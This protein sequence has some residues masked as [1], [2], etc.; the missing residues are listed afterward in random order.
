V[1]RFRFI[2]A[3]KAHHAV[4]LLCRVLEVST[5]G[6]YAWTQRPPS[7]RAEADGAL[8]ARIRAV[9]RASRGTYGAP[10][11]HAELR[12][13]GRPVARKRIARLM[14]TDGLRGCRPRRFVRT[15]LAEPAATAPDLVQRRF[16]ATAPD[17]L[18]LTDITYVPT[19]EGWLYLAA[20]L[21]GYSRRVVGWSL[22]DHL[23]TDLALA[24]L[25]MAL[26]ARQPAPG[27]IHHSDRG[28]QY[29]AVAYTTTLDRHGLRRSLGQPGTCWDNAVAESFFATL[30][31]ELVHRRRWATR[32]QA[33]TAIFEYIEIFYNRQRRHSSLGYESPADFEA[34]RAQEVHAA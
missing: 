4:A 8:T 9:H 1:S 25:R 17:R 5:S 29:T 10:R 28:C 31:T 3:E 14:R 26:Q 33:T 24:A 18:W 15:T 23:R 27:L 13:Q 32:Q 20:V 22:T 19:D 6:Y 34:T 12:A 16:T 2:A 7:A 11:V 30:K 21:D